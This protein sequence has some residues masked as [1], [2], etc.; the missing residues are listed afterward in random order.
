[1]SVSIY[2][3]ARRNRRITDAEQAA[4]DELVSKYSVD[5][6]IEE[7]LRSGLGLN[8]ES[9]RIYQHPEDQSGGVVFE[10]ATKVP[11]NSEDGLWE[12]V[13]H[14]SGLLSRIRHVLRDAQWQVSLDDHELVWD[15]ERGEYDLRR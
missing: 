11:D 3:I 14:W 4:I 8:W 15:S 10:G 2:Y 6:R 7:F 13:R 1:L 5:S 12:G 9:F